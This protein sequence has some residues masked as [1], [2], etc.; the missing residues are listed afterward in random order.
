MSRY[1]EY[2]SNVQKSLKDL[3]SICQRCVLRF[4]GV[5][6]SREHR[7]ITIENA[8]DE[9]RESG[10][11][12]RKELSDQTQTERLE[13]VP[14]E[15]KRRTNGEEGQIEQENNSTMTNNIC[16]ACLG[17][18]Q[19][20]FIQTIIDDVSKEI[21]NSQYDSK[22]FTIALGLPVSLALRSHSLNLYLEEKLDSF[23]EEEVTPI[24]QVWK[25]LFPQRIAQKIGKTLVTGD[26]SEFY[27][28]LHF[29]FAA[30]EDELSCLRKM[31]EEEYRD[32]QKNHKKYHM[33]LVTRQGAEKSLQ[34]V[35]AEHFKTHYPVPPQPPETSLKYKVKMYH[36]SIYI[37]GRY[38]KYSRELPQTP[39]I[40][41]G[42]KIMPSSVEELMQEHL[43]NA[44]T[45]DFAK[46]SSS[47]REDVDVRTLGRGRPFMFE[48][49]NSRTVNFT[50]EE[51]LQIQK[52]INNNTK[53]IFVRDLQVVNK[54]S[55]KSLKDGEDMKKKTYTAL[56]SIPKEMATD[57]VVGSISR[58]NE[59]DEIKLSQRTPI[60][61]LHRRP[62]ALRTRSVY[63]M[64]V[65]LNVEKNINIENESLFT[66]KLS[67]CTQAGTYVKEFV[68]GDFGR[69][70]PNLCSI[71][72]CD[73]DIIALDVEA[74]DLDWPP[75]LSSEMLE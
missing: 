24:K 46:F 29:E 5:K 15:K 45:F 74:I 57:T 22:H 58:L 27:A 39:W 10:A 75:S 65:D 35:T 72:N 40:L 63:N 26:F 44:F 20:N 51:L 48:I 3:G 68:H 37:A 14:S 16:I 56:C 41:D 19:E 70:T 9:D 28:E 13:Y 4:G 47:G 60:R 17:V 54:E 67:L 42:K 6:S 71:L 25:W 34:N 21:I 73:V 53:D 64:K 7:N 8:V 49:I 18:L 61:V 55:I 33:G 12:K 52:D 23:D 30:D 2:L 50:P 59:M 62:N 66:F 32:R 69:T 38:N 1:N 36:N 11:A 43:K 31:C